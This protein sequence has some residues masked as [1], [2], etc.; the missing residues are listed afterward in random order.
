MEASVNGDGS[1]LSGIWLTVSVVVYYSAKI[2]WQVIAHRR[3]M[4]ELKAESVRNTVR[5]QAAHEARM[6]ALDRISERDVRRA[7]L[8][9]QYVRG[10]DGQSE[11]KPVEATEPGMRPHGLEPP[12]NL[13]DDGA[14]RVPPDHRPTIR[15]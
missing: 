13:G 5:E 1:M 15:G 11:P 9:R 2:A 7:K 8:L 12:A 4:R 14:P 3:E 10:Q 6:K